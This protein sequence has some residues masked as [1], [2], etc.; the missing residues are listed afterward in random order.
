MV[1]DVHN[2]FY[3]RAYLEIVKKGGCVA[4][5]GTGE[6]GE[7]TIIY[8]GDFNY[9]DR[10]HRDEQFRLMEMDK[11]GVDIQV[12]SMTTPGVHVEEAGRGVEMARAV[13]E[14]FQS[15]VK[16]SA[17]RYKALAALPL[18]VPAKAAEELEYAV[19]RLSLSGGTMFTN[20]NGKFFDSPEFEPIFE[21]AQRLDVP[22]FFHPTTPHP[23]DLF[24][25]Y[26]L[27]A[28]VGFT[29]DTTLSISRLIFSGMLDKYP[30]LK[31]VASHLG[32]NL[33]YLAERLDRGYAVYPECQ[34]PL[35]KPSDYLKKIYYDCVLFDPRAVA[36]AVD[37]LGVNQ[38]MA[39][40][41]YPHQIGS[42]EKAVSVIRSLPYDTTTRETISSVNA[43]RVFKI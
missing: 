23:A 10:G 35:N 36:F 13:N 20:A 38:F 15:I 25:D 11:A 43:K 2:H 22:L 5:A 41:D 28:T 8:E 19:T 1:I 24:L 42:M 37:T 14:G 32:G 33:P 21:T 16:E 3:P 34:K 26:R 39:G 29:V 6:G 17:G 12:L 18:Q 31:I 27:A 30:R 9:V 7:P 40:S 4:K